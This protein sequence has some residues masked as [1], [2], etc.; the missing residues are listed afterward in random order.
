[1]RLVRSQERAGV[2]N[3]FW[4]TGTTQWHSSHERLLV[5]RLSQ[6]KIRPAETLSVSTS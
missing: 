2:A 5:F 3:I 6:E 1:V 4:Q